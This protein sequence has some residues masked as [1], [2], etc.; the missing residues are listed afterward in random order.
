M[1]PYRPC[2]L[3]MF[4]LLVG[5]SAVPASAITPPMQSA[6]SEVGYRAPSSPSGD[7]FF[8]PEPEPDEPEPNPMPSPTC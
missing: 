7:G 8:W 4:A 2:A 1:N 5:T 6:K 3:A